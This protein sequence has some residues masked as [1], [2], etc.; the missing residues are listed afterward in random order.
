MFCKDVLDDIS[1]VN[2]YDSTEI[3]GVI[4][5][6]HTYLWVSVFFARLIARP[7]DNM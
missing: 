5:D 7:L 6:S 2:R 3:I 1:P 4:A